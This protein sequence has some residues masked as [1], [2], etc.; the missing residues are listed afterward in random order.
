MTD[1][2][3][4][5]NQL[6]GAVLNGSYRLQRLL[7]EGAMGAVYE[8]ESLRGEGPRAIKILHAEF[9]G[10]EQVVQ[11]FFAEAQAAGALNH[12]NVARVYS[13]STAEDGTPYLVMELLKGIP[14]SSYLDHGKAIA[15]QQAAPII[16]GVLQALGAAHAHRIV[17]RDL[18]PDNLFLVRAD[19]GSYQVKVLDFG[20]AKVI[21]AAGGM[22]SKT[23]TGVLLGTPGYMS[24]EQIKNAKG[25]DPRSDL[26]SVAI[27]LYEMLTAKEPFPTS[28]GFAALTAVLTEEPRPI[29]RD[30]PELACWTGFFRRGFAKD[31]NE[32]FQTAAEMSDALMQVARGVAY[33]GPAAVALLRP[34]LSEA[35]GGPAPAP[36]APIPPSPTHVSTVHPGELSTL[37]GGDPLVSVVSARRPSPGIALWLAAV[38]GFVCLGLGFTAGL[39]LGAR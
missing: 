7:G 38:I 23:R 10:E 5:A 9:V 39:L 28:G 21:D 32:R 6:V 26:W 14:L 31:P 12:R 20:I 8:A 22:G 37:T 17:H 27:I 24:P 16:H 34:T 15:T 11:R 19:D 29:D 25:V 33:E 36:V 13:A 30:A 3:S 18:K 35:V 2:A 4:S 1:Q